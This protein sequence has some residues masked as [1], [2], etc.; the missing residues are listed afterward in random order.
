MSPVRLTDTPSG[1]PGR[2]SPAAAPPVRRT[3]G[4]WASGP[5][6]RLLAR[7]VGCYGAAA[8]GLFAAGWLLGDATWWLYVSNLSAFYW[9]APAVPLVVLAALARWWPAAVLCALA[10]AV[11]LATF[12]PAF[13]PQS[14]DVAPDLRVASYNVD[15]EPG[16]AHVGELVARVQPDVLLVQEV[17]PAARDELL[18]QV[19]SLP[20]H[21]FAPVNSA[22]P[23]GGGTA[24]LSRLPIV[25]ARPIAGLPVGSRPVNIV[26]V[27]T[28]AGP[29]QVASLHLTSPCSDCTDDPPRITEQGLAAEAV[30]RRA[31]AERIAAALPDGPLVVGGDLNSSTL[32]TPRRRLLAAGLVDLHRAVGSGAGFTRHDWH[33]WFRIDWLL[34]SREVTPVDEWVD[35][36]QGSD[37]QPV[38]ADVAVP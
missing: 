22:A 28:D 24:V 5:G 27:A 37:H 9:L 13:V 30:T 18:A 19:P 16:L 32:N 10:A 36:Q 7:V 11:W 35:G 15:P 1:S 26:T 14:V 20:Y 34:A 12:A 2:G 6:S 4:S 25:A 31:E 23:G 21:D 3:A 29:V 17:L 33:A 8:V 38:V